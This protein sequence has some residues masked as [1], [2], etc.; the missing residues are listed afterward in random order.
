MSALQVKPDVLVFD[1]NETLLDLSA[2]QPEFNRIFD[3]DLA[4]KDWFSL[5]LHYSLVSTIAAQY[6]DFESLGRA[7]LQMLAGTRRVLLPTEDEDRV[8][9]S[10]KTLP[11]HPEVPEALERLLEAGFR[12]AALTNSSS[13]MIRAQLNNSRLADYFEIAISVE[14]VRRYKPHPAVYE[15]AA[16]R[17]GTPAPGACLIAAHAWDVY[18]AMNAGWSAAFVARP[19]K[20]LFPV[21]NKPIVVAKDMNGIAD[22]LLGSVPTV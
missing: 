6:H 5:L 20:V 14:E 13:S 16:R 4:L 12:M 21:A 1:V 11:A 9:Q 19:G 17:L 18:G 10:M 7:T 8:L 2:M 3:D 15:H 22:A